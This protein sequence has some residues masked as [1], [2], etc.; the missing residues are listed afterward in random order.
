MNYQLHDSQI[1]GFELGE[2]IIIFNFSQGF[3]ATDENGKQ[4]EQLEGCRIVFEIDTN[5][6]PIED[7]VSVRISKRGG[8]YKTTALMKFGDLLKKTPF[9]VDM[10]YDCSFANR[11]MLQTY[12]D[13]Q[14]ICAEIFISDIESVK[15]FHE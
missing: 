2:N 6:L 13:G 3:W 9:N 4:V 8:D 10:E 11:K 7:F 12:S 14:H 1:N 15:Y 5:G